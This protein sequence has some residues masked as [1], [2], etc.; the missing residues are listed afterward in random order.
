MV[1]NANEKQFLME[2]ARVRVC[3]MF[4]VVVV[5]FTLVFFN[6]FLSTYLL[7]TSQ[8]L[9]CTPSLVPPS[10]C[11]S[12]L[13]TFF[14]SHSLRPKYMSPL[15]NYESKALFSLRISIMV[16]PGTRKNEICEFHREITS[17]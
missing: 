8:I 12:H 4:F 7:Y 15:Q 14:F 9:E 16:S 11:D 2:R 1:L 5:F 6:W 17:S 10:S 13:F 3:V